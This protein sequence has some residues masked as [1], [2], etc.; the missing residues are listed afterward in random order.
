M[1]AGTKELAGN[2]HI[3][4]FTFSRTLKYTILSCVQILNSF[5]K[6]NQRIKA[7]DKNCG[8]ETYK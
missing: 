1:F 6:L 3:P 2:K 5:L 7:L 8:N 4:A